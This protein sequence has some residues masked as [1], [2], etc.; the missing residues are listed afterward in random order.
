MVELE[1]VRPRD[2]V[3]L[4]GK[5]CVIHEIDVDGGFVIIRDGGDLHHVMDHQLRVVNETLVVDSY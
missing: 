1:S 5:E 2:D 3:I 4:E